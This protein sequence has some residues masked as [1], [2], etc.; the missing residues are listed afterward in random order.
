MAEI[1]EAQ[2]IHTSERA[3][4]W[5]NSSKI[6]TRIVYQLVLELETP[7]HIGSGESGGVL[8]MPLLRDPGDGRPMITG[9][10]LAGALR[11]YLAKSDP[12]AAEE[13]F[14]VV[15]AGES[16][17]SWVRVGNARLIDADT[18]TIVRDGVGINPVNRAASA[19]L[20]YDLELLEAGT[21]FVFDLELLLPQGG[22]N[23]EDLMKKAISG[24]NGSIRL[25]KRK[26]RG[27]GK[28][29]IQSGK[30]WKYDLPKDLI[31][32]LESPKS[33]ASEEWKKIDLAQLSS[34]AV[35]AFQDFQVELTCT[36]ESSLLIRA[37]PSAID[38]GT[39]NLPDQEMIRASR[40]VKRNGRIERQTQM[41]IPGT[42]L[43]GVLRARLERIANTLKP[44]SGKEWAS[45]LFGEG[46]QSNGA[47]HSSRIWVDE[48]VIEQPNEWVHTRVKIDRFT[49]GA[50]H[51]ALFSEGLLLPS[52]KTSFTLKFHL[53]GADKEEARM[54]LLLV[55]DLWTA[56][57]PVGGEAGVGRGRLRGKKAVIRWQ[58]HLWTIEAK[59]KD[60]IIVTSSTGTPDLEKLLEGKQGGKND[61]NA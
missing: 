8:D 17:E 49:G 21:T 54:L 28:V 31:R 10:T 48:T 14:G 50:A 29:K 22:S 51:G 19:K 34:P 12:K 39:K 5:H 20:K 37:V 4:Q 42:S 61:A 15:T 44:G 46:H 45:R 30:V 60:M 25:G 27:F 40:T 41:I 58:G 3:A 56:D 38:P 55:K 18:N 16:R 57:L 33:E 35:A 59:D 2:T 6:A 36:L 11:A 52:E 7:T 43:A 32:W 9:A 53:D 24:L 26:R 1:D 13:L 23:Y 47:F